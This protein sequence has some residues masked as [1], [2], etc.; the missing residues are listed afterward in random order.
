MM[1][2]G[3]ENFIIILLRTGRTQKIILVIAYM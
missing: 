1:Y 2:G 3:Q